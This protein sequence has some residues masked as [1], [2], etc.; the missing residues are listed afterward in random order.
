MN[1]SF[2]RAQFR[3]EAHQVVRLYDPEGTRVECVSG[4]LWITQDSDHLDHWLESNGALTLDRP[5][6]ALIH[7][8]KPSEI[9]LFEPAPPP[10]L[11]NRIGHALTAASCAIGR[12][13]V[14]QFGPESI[15]KRRQPGWYNGL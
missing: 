4:A 6:L 2:D 14:R 15:D 1:L 5:G 3:L 11:R 13:F 8:Q 7:A 9:V 10:G 12:W